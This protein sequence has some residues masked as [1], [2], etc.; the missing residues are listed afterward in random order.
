[1]HGGETTSKQ[2]PSRWLRLLIL[3]VLVGGVTGSLSAFFLISLEAVSA[4]HVRNPWLLLLLPVAGIAI[5][6]FYKTYG[7]LAEQGSHLLVEEIHEQKGNVPLRMAPMVLFATLLTHLFGGS[8]GR[9][10]TSVQMGGAVAAWLS[11]AFA[12]NKEQQRILLMAGIAAGFGSVFGTPWAGAVFAIELP[13]RGRWHAR[14]LLPALIASWVGHAICLAWGVEHTDFRSLGLT[15]DGLLGFSWPLF[16]YV[17]VAAV[18]FGCCGRFFV[19]LSHSVPLWFEKLSPNPLWRPFWGGMMV[20]FLVYALGSADYLGLG[21]VAVREG[22]ISLLSSFTA[23]G[24]DPWTWFWKLL[25]TIITLASGFKGGEVTPLLFIGAALGNAL[26]L[27]M[28][29]PVE[30]FAGLGLIAVFA[31]ASNTP[32]A[33]TFLGI[34]IFGCHGIAWFALACLISFLV[35]GRE[36]IYKNQRS[37]SQTFSRRQQGVGKEQASDEC[38]K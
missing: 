17:I 31:A 3:L 11:R 33:C 16:F 23:G 38:D 12:P 20:I 35:S 28:G 1:M 10:G 29:Q 2:W 9:E 25:F 7:T 5:A 6:W 27:A 36:G 19:I 14:Y 18:A 26:A 15:K 21:V 4:Y 24:A 22:G 13:V 37:C 30:I 34:E 32:L 8:A